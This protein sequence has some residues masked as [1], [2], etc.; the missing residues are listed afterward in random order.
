[1]IAEVVFNIPIDRA[2]HYLIPAVDKAKLKPGMRV[3][4]PFGSKE[5]IGFV[6]RILPSSKF[7][8]LKSFKN[9]LDLYPVISD[10]RW[11]L[12]KWIVRYYGCSYGEALSTMVPSG[13]RIKAQHLDLLE[14]SDCADVDLQNT[15]P[16]DLT[17]HQSRAL[18]ELEGMIDKSGKG[19]KEYSQDILSAIIL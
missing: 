6:V 15:N 18:F 14:S 7:P 12:A 10:H 2:F 9:I 3:V 19:V 11:N 16:V 1:M 17:S 13:L 5:H 8:R 4:A